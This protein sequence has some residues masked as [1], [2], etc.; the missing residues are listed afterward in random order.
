MIKVTNLKRKKFNK[1]QITEIQEKSKTCQKEQLE[2]IY[3]QINKIENSVEK[4][5]LAWK[6]INKVSGKKSN[7]RS[8]LRAANQAKRF[9]KW[10]EHFKNLLRNTSEITDKATEEIIH[11]QQ[12]IEHWCFSEDEL[13][14]VLKTIK[15]RKTAGLHEILPDVWKTD[16]DYIHHFFVDIRWLEEST[17]AVTDRDGWWESM[18]RIGAINTSWW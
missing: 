1:H 3:C 12:D 11:D 13:D 10:K 2:Y 5:Q 9:Q 4:S 8:K 18:K 6:T 7:S 15:S 17:R 16:M 14:T